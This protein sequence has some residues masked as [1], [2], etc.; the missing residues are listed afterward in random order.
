MGDSVNTF[1][2]KRVRSPIEP[3]ATGRA[4][5]LVLT[6]AV[7]ASAVLLIGLDAHLTFVADD[8]DLLLKRQ[9]ASPS[10][11]LDPFN[12]NIVLGPTAIFK[13]L[14]A[15][16]GMGSALPYYIVS[17]SLFLASA[18][19]LFVYLRPRVGDWLALFGTVLILFMGAAFED[20]LWA[21]QMGY[22]GSMAAGMGMLLAFDRHEEAS[23]RIAC[24]LL[25]ISL[26]FSSL[27]LV[28]A[29]GALAD[30][31]L[32]RRPRTARAYVAL[33]PLALFAVWW[34]GWGHTA[35]SHLSLHNLYHLPQYVVGAAGAGIVSLLGLATGAGNDSHQSHQIWGDALLL[36]GVAVAAFR[37]IRVGRVSRGLVIALVL[38]LA[39]WALAGLNQSPERFPASSRYQYPSGVFLLLIAAETLRGLRAPRITKAGI[40]AVTGLALIGGVSLLHRK[41]TERWEPNADSRRSILAAVDIAGPSAKPSFKVAFSPSISVP[42]RTYLSAADSYGSP[43][44]SEAELEARP[45]AER[46]KADRV[47]VKALGLA[48]AS[49][50]PS[51]HTLRCENL[52]ASATGSAGVSLLRSEFTLRNDSRFGVDVMLGRFSNG[53]PI[54]LGSLHAG[55]KAGLAIPVDNSNRPW[56]LGVRGRG[57]VRLCRTTPLR[58][59]I[60]S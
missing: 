13:L 28:F 49:P 32:G 26:S 33:V 23:D 15:V 1:L 56:S 42:V 17:V 39:F 40:A 36:I 45:Q 43:A 31:Y 4:A 11:F 16:F 58:E 48:L 34:L 55:A 52:R 18:V 10:V 57:R 60:T 35:R 22:F 29:I 51:R 54:R 30:L 6:V 14:L 46:V 59:R 5:V 27:G 3:P 37:I 50:S 21:F 2:A 19:L 7:V 20:L 44:F 8:W 12:E 38:A 24:G 41:Y 47:L 25:A 9:G 53:V